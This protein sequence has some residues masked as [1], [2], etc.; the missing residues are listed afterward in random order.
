M[1]E[2][3]ASSVRGGGMD[4]TGRPVA[5]SAGKATEA[6]IALRY[7]ARATNYAPTR[8]ERETLAKC[9]EYARMLWRAGVIVGGGS[10]LGISSAVRVHWAQRLAVS[11]AFASSLAGGVT[12][13]TCQTPEKS[14]CGGCGLIL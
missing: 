1:S 8:V 12:L 11:A 10:G 3:S 7:W 2:R 13:T 9:D 4:L 5:A 14:A 6:I